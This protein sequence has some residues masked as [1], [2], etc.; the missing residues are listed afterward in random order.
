MEQKETLHV[1]RYIIIYKIT[2]GLLEFLSGLGIALFGRQLFVQIM[3]RLSLELTE[4]P[5]DFLANLSYKIIP[6]YFVHNT[7]IVTSLILIGMAKIIGAIG[8]MN[9]QNWGVDLLVGLT[10]VM[11]PFQII[12]IIAQPTFFNFFFMLT[13]MMIALYLMRFKPKAWI[14]R[15]F[16]KSY[17]GIP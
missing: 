12:H 10:V 16:Q 4:D 15:V 17:W 8:L 7:I 5:H 9:K 14:S 13:G 11:L 3:L 6:N 1:S 2:A